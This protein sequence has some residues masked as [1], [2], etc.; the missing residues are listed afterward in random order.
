MISSRYMSKEFHGIMLDTGAA[1]TSTAG[2]GQAKAG[3]GSKEG[4]DTQRDLAKSLSISVFAIVGKDISKYGRGLI[5]QQATPYLNIIR[6]YILQCCLSKHI[7]YYVYVVSS[8]TLGWGLTVF[9]FY[10][11]TDLLSKHHKQTCK[12]L[13]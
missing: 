12:S 11:K 5:S 1:N 6:G 2:Y 13:F 9:A 4:M 7:S 10:D 8:I 3:E